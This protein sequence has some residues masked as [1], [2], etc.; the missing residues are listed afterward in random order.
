MTYLPTMGSIDPINFND[1]LKPSIAFARN[2]VTHALYILLQVQLN[3]AAYAR[4]MPTRI[5]AD[6]MIGERTRALAKE[7]GFSNTDSIRS[8]ASHAD[9]IAVGAKAIADSANAP[10]TVPAPKPPSPP[11]MIDPKTETLVAAPA[12]SIMDS[13]KNMSTTTMVALGVAAVGVGFLL[14]RKKGS[15][16]PRSRR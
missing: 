2:P 10:Q 7:I 8:V 15:T 16:K 13:F 1:T 6:G 3:R 12:A 4:K 11:M 9:S 5:P 14:T